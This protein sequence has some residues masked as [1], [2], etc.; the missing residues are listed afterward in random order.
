MSFNPATEWAEII[1][2]SRPAEG[3]SEPEQLLSAFFAASNVGLSIVDTQLNYQAI[4]KTLAEMNG[5]PIEAHLG[6]SMRDVLGDAAES[7]EPILRRVLLTGEPAT[8]VQ[9][10]LKLPTRAEVGHWVVHYFPMNDASGKVTR[11]GVVV[12]EVTEQKKLEEKIASLEGKLEQEKGRRHMLL[13]ISTALNSSPDLQQSFPSISASIR[14]VIPHDWIEVSLVDEPSALVRTYVADCPLDPGLAGP[15]VATPLGDSIC[16]KAVAE[17]QAVIAGRGGLGAIPSA[18]VEQLLQKG[19]QSACCMPFVTPKGSLGSLNLASVED[20]AFRSED[21]DALKQIGLLVGNALDHTL[22]HCDPSENGR[23]GRTP[24]FDVEGKT[25]SELDVEE[26]VGE[27]PA[28]RRVLDQSKTVARSEATVLILGDTGTGKELIARAIHHMSSRKNAP[29]IKLNCAAIPGGLLESELFGHERGAFTGAFAR[30]LGRLEL[31]NHGTLFLDEIGD[32]PLELQPKL[33]RVLQDQEF[34][35]LGGNRTLR[36]DIRLLAATNRDLAISLAQGRFRADLFYRLNVFPI[37]VPALGERSQDI[38]HLVR[39]FTQKY[40]RKMNKKIDTIPA[41]AMDALEA[42]QWPGNI[43]ELENF[44]EKSV[45][46]SDGP[47]LNVPFTELRPHTSPPSLTLE[48]MGREYILR[49]LRECL[50]MIEGPKGAAARL[51]MHPATLHSM[52]QRMRISSKD[53]PC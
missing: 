20:H 43:R 37:R 15:K 13:E 46:L 42:W 17:G 1:G 19:I 31:A 25:L 49:A 50:G 18:F 48:G 36:V 8:N 22:A 44:I 35:R 2:W 11:I 34:E 21:L 53:Y 45:I 4:N 40:A 5:F 29:F 38:P 24:S 47:V 9:L 32:L 51:G 52:M 16:G 30:K 12:V 27:S 14:K 39:Y 7:I 3:C 26:I 10:T 23:K 6:K 28:L 41:E 33:L